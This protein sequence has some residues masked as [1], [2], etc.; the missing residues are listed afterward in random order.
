MSDRADRDK[1]DEREKAKLKYFISY[2][3]ADDEPDTDDVRVV[4]KFME[5]LRSKLK[6][7]G[8]VHGVSFEYYYSKH[9]HTSQ[10]KI[11]QI[12]DKE[13]DDLHFL[14]AVVSE[15]YI[16]RE[17][18]PNWCLYELRRFIG[19]RSESSVFPI[20]LDDVKCEELKDVKRRK[21]FTT[22]DGLPMPF[23]AG[24]AYNREVIALA[25]AIREKWDDQSKRSGPPPAEAGAL[26]RAV[27]SVLPRERLKKAFLVDGGPNDKDFVRKVGSAIKANGAQYVGFAAKSPGQSRYD[28]AAVEWR[29]SVYDSDVVV[30]VRS[31]GPPSYVENRA[32]LAARAI[33][34]GDEEL[35]RAR[36]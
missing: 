5:Q 15:A 32:I 31:M 10:D 13:I 14:V 4:D 12:I 8:L 21:F 29:N 22:D 9:D 33:A 30:L 17:K 36:R 3:F 24:R 27:S 11:K 23:V 34:A 2:A 35:G 18:D 28:H 7:R 1:Q 19:R 26:A 16:S 25:R 20:F 6:Q